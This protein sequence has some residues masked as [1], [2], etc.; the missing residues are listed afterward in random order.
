MA[1]WVDITGLALSGDKLAI[2]TDGKI[3][4]HMPSQSITE[5]ITGPDMLPISSKAV[6]VVWVGEDIVFCEDHC[7][8]SFKSNVVSVIA[9]EC[10]GDAD[11]SGAHS[12]LC[13]PV[14][15]CA[16]FDRDIYIADS[17]SGSVKLINRPL[18][19]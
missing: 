1:D 4:L 18:K 16:E 12:K 3:Y 8:K 13:Q 17:G 10:K 15:I 7:V 11:R 2:C 14:G 9:G 6:N 5:V 19:G